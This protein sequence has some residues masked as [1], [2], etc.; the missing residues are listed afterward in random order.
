MTIESEAI[1]IAFGKTGLSSKHFF[2]NVRCPLL[3]KRSQ[4][5]ER[6]LRKDFRRSEN[7]EQE[8]SGEKC[9]RPPFISCGCWLHRGAAISSKQEMQMPGETGH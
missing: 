9:S 2:T 3:A 1:R 7:Y 4:R 8:M 6:D 5:R